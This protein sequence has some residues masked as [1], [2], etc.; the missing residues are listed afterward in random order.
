M[1]VV[2][3]RF[4]PYIDEIRLDDTVEAGWT[5][6][7]AWRKT[8]SFLFPLPGKEVTK[9]LIAAVSWNPSCSGV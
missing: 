5:K 4:M 8:I 3:K 6:Y 2:L 9:E 1:I 7:G